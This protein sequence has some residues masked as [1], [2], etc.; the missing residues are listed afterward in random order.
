[1]RALLYV[2]CLDIQLL[3]FVL[4]V[5]AHL[6]ESLFAVDRDVEGGRDG[7]VTVQVVGQEG[8]LTVWFLVV[9]CLVED[10]NAPIVAAHGLETVLV[11]DEG[12]AALLT[13]TLWRAS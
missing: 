13:E 8:A 3:Y 2:A 7:E 4:L 5:A 10:V 1:M 6:Q 9:A 12:H 11:R